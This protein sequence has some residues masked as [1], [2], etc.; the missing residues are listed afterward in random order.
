MGKLSETRDE[1]MTVLEVLS[2]LGG[3][4][5]YTFYRWRRTGVGPP[6]LKL[7]N[8]D[9]RIRRGDFADWLETLRSDAA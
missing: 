4:S 2:A 1:L 7:P 9:L 5:R 8:G 6:C 3:V